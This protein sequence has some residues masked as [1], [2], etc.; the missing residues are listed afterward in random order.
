MTRRFG[1]G[2]LCDGR[3]DLQMVNVLWANETTAARGRILEHRAEGARSRAEV[4]AW[5][6]KSNGTTTVVG[7]AN[8]LEL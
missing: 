3:F 4:E 7:T 8:A 5:C 2:F 1:V 6:E